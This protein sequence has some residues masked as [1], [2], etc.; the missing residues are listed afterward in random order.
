MIYTI[1]TNSGT[2]LVEKTKGGCLVFDC[3]TN[4]TWF[5][6]VREP[7]IAAGLTGTRVAKPVER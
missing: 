3:V 1:T 4:K 6:P 5:V 2:K 7:K